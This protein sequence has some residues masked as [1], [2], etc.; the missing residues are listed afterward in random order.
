MNTSTLRQELHE[1]IDSAD[2]GLLK[3]IYEILQAASVESDELSDEHRLILDKRLKAYYENP[4]D[5]LTWE[6]VK[7][8]YKKS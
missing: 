2:E 5:V 6:E 3:T 4:E 7:A 8:I 1:Y